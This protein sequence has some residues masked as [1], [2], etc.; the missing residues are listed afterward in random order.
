MLRM[1]AKEFQRNIGRAQHAALKEP[2]AVTFHGRDHLVL[3]SA[4]EYHR[5]AKNAKSDIG[6]GKTTRAD[7]IDRLVQLAPRLRGKGIASLSLFGSVARG[8]DTPE[9]DV[10]ILA[11]LSPGTPFGLLD[12]VGLQDELR[13]ELGRPVELALEG[14][15]D[16]LVRD[17]VATD[18]IKIF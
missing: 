9:S 15:L 13:D 1:T 2:V 17:N 3:L 18:L 14:G 16:P 5:L 7:V 12:L 10:D 11:R 8:E 4:E 6:K